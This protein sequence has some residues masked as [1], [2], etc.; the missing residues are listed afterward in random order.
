MLDD[1]LRVCFPHSS[2][3]TKQGNLYWILLVWLGAKRLPFDIKLL[4]FSST[5]HTAY[6]YASPCQCIGRCA[7]RNA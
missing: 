6:A 4:V 5:Q 2:K 3:R 1:L 7:R